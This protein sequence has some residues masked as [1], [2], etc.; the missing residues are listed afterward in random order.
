MINNNTAIY[1][2]D[3]LPYDET[4]YRTRF[5]FDLNSITMASGNT[6]YIFQAYTREDVVVARLEFRYYSGSYQLRAQAVNNSSTW[7]STSWYAITDAPHYIELLW[8]AASAPG[9]N[10]GILTLWVDGS[11]QGNFT[12]LANDTRRVDYVNLGAVSGIDTA[13]RGTYYFDTFESRRNSYIGPAAF[14]ANPPGG[15]PSQAGKRW[16]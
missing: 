4:S 5:Y 16:C 7:S 10:N 13:T 15:C 14:S 6:H 1:V 2:T 12:N 9:A 3:W 11:Q 8:Q